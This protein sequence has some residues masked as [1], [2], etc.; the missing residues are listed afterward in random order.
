MLEK[1]SFEQVRE[2]LASDP[3][4]FKLISKEQFSTHFKD[5][6]VIGL[7]NT[8]QKWNAEHK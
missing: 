4:A 2:I 1:D 8:F 7:T 6:N 5:I 3:I